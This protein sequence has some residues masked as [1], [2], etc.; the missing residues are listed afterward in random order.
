MKIK[1]LGA[2]LVAALTVASVAK[3]Q[4]RTPLLTE[5]SQNQRARIHEGVRTG[6]LTH[7]ETK[8]LSKRELKLRK[9]IAKAKADGYVSP[10]EN[11]KLLRKQGR[12]N[13]AIIRKK[14]NS[15]NQY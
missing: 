15:R 14:T 9:D 5:R 7:S 11:R 1:F 2:L 3:A 13:R 8:T 10:K 4:T 6:T 12:L